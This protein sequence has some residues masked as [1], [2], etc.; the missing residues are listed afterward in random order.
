MHKHNKRATSMQFAL[1]LVTAGAGLRT[2][3]LLELCLY[4]LGLC[5]L[6]LTSCAWGLPVSS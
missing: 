6:S 1:K 5:Q 3:L 4:A 2:L